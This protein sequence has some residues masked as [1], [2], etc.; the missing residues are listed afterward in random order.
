M[1][2]FVERV[3]RFL[4]PI[5]LPDGHDAESVKGAFSDA[6]TDLP[7]PAGNGRGSRLMPKAIER[8]WDSRR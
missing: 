3:S 4:C 8:T 1:G 2:T 5:A 7:A 6:V